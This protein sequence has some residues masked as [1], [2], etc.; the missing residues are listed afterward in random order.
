MDWIEPPTSGMI[1]LQLTFWENKKGI[2]N[3][4]ASVNVL[5]NLADFASYFTA[6][7]ETTEAVVTLLNRP[8]F[9]SSATAEQLATVNSRRR[10]VTQPT[11]RSKRPCMPVSPAEIGRIF[12]VDQ[13]FSTWW[14]DGRSIRDNRLTIIS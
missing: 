10:T 11:N 13:I 7:F 9:V 2:E 8:S 12:R 6:P 1:K 4:T 5:F 14:F 3:S